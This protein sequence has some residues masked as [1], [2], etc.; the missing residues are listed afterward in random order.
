LQLLY[1]RSQHSCMGFRVSRIRMS[2]ISR[3]EYES[4]LVKNFRLFSRICG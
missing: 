1:C 4:F 3:R 2:E